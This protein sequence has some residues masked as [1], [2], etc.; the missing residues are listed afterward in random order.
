MKNTHPLKSIKD[1][2]E[3][4]GILEGEDYIFSLQG[5]TVITTSKG[6]PKITPEIRRDLEIL[7]VAVL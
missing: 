6:A 2:L 4:Q 7:R 5:P 1:L 3:A